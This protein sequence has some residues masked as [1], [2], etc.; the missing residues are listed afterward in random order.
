MNELI[1]ELLGSAKCVVLDWML[2][3]LCMLGPSTDIPIEF[4]GEIP[5]KVPVS[6]V[7]A[8]IAVVN[9]NRCRRVC[10]R[11]VV[12]VAAL[13]AAD[14]SPERGEERERRYVT[15]SY[16]PSCVYCPTPFG[17]IIVSPC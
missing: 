8:Q 13:Y 1:V 5:G 16:Q 17:E 6:V 3:R 4:L 14:L 7:D 15:L 9:L 2:V 11:I 10:A 12:R